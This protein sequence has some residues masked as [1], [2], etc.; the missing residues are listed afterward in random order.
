MPTNWQKK[1]PGSGREGLKQKTWLQLFS[2]MERSPKGSTVQ[3]A[4]QDRPAK[5]ITSLTHQMEQE[6]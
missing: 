5:W 1:Q 6:M 2:V 3:K 4:A